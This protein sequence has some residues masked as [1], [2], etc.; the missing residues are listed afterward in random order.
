MITGLV[1]RLAGYPHRKKRAYGR[2]P[3]GKLIEPIRQPETGS[4]RQP[5]EREH[6][7][8]EGGTRD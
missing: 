6:G 2:A 7:D 5:Q 4:T 3:Q 8:A 1:P